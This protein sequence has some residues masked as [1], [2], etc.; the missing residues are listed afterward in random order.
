MAKDI[1]LDYNDGKTITGADAILQ[2]Y[3][4]ALFTM[5][6]E[7]S[8]DPEFGIGIEQFVGEPN[9]ENTAYVIEQHIRSLT[10]RFF[11]E[12]TIANMFLEKPQ[13]NQITINMNIIIVPYAARRTI[14]KNVTTT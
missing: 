2:Q 8:P 12:I 3:E 7:F 13:E 5:P 6:T 1:S 4:I 11:P 10:N 9:T 14:R